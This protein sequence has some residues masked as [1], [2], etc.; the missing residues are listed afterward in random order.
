M[1]ECKSMWVEILLRGK[2]KFLIKSAC[3]L[4]NQTLARSKKNRKKERKGT[5]RK[6][7]FLLL[8]CTIRKHWKREGHNR[9]HIITSETESLTVSRARRRRLRSILAS[10]KVDSRTEHSSGERAMLRPRFAR[11][12]HNVYVQS[13]KCTL[14]FIHAIAIRRT[15]CFSVSSFLIVRLFCTTDK[16]T[17]HRTKKRMKIVA[18]IPLVVCV[19]H[20]Y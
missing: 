20:N 2:K 6:I 8:L 1:S 7:R 16:W 4:K 18:Y 14:R 5:K 13:L 11:K 19:L 15:R 12:N 3:L 17:R 9:F 10:T